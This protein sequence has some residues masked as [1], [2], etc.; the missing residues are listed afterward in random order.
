MERRAA[1][2]GAIH[3]VHRIAAPHEPV[4]PA[5]TA[6]RSA[7]EIQPL[8]AA[9]MHHHDR[10]AMLQLLRNPVL[11]VHLRAERRPGRR[12]GALATGPEEALRR[13]SQRPCAAGT[14]I[15]GPYGFDRSSH[16]NLP[17]ARRLLTA[18]PGWNRPS[19]TPSP[20]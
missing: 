13:Q 15:L 7:E 6:I 18:L 1:V 4:D 19:C 11:N 16:Q 14:Q 12:L 20:R 2:P 17:A 9:A 5:F 10:P 3:Y 8:A